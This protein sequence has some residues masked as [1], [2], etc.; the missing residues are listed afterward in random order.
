MKNFFSLRTGA[1]VFIQLDTIHQTLQNHHKSQHTNSLS[2]SM[3]TE[4]WVIRSIYSCRLNAAQAG[5]TSIE[6]YASFF[7]I[8]NWGD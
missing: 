2:T 1:R 7:V 5:I 3:N 4:N 6:P 8:K